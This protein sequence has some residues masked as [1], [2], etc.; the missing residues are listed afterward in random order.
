MPEM[1]TVSELAAKKAQQLLEKSGK[2]GAALRVRVI[3]GGCSGLEY[4]IEPDAEAPKPGDTVVES[5]GVK[6][7][8]DAKGLLYLAGSEL[9]YK[10]SLMASGFK[11]H[12]PQAA[13]ECACGQSFTV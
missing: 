13:A 4:K 5:R 9:D 12:N 2:I 8:L 3:S 6:V 7:Y 10:S 1:F 11:I